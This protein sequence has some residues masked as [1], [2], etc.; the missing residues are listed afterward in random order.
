MLSIKKQ[1]KNII[2][3]CNSPSCYVNDSLNLIKEVEKILG[4]KS[5]ESTKKYSLHITSC[6]GC[7]DKAPAMMINDKV[8]DNLTKEKI[9]KLLR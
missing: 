2:R 7:C 6:I 1:G 9:R 4:I 3:I 8:Y 5:G